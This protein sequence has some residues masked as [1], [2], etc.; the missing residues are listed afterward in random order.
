MLLSEPT[1]SGTEVPDQSRQQKPSAA[2]SGSTARAAVP[3]GDQRGT[4]V[5]DDF[6]PTPAMLTW[7]RAHCPE[8]PAAEHERFMDYWRGVSGS[9]GVKRDWVAT[10]RN[11]MR[12]AADDI[13]KGKRPAAGPR[14]STTDERVAAGLALAAKYD[15]ED[16]TATVH[17]LPIGGTA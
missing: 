5:P 7:V 16:G 8:V 9:R 15:A 10:W 13:R 6:T 12:T 11:W 4:R 1:T 17:Q 14:R 3:S 2:R